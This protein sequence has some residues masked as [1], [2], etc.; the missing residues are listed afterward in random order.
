MSNTRV[1]FCGITRTED[2]R[3]A[4]SL[5]VDALGLVFVGRSVRA[6]TPQRAAEICAALP[7]LVT[8]VGLFMNPSEN[9][10]RDVLERVPLNWLQF[11]GGE[12]PEF[13]GR[14]GLPYIKALPMA[15]PGDVQYAPWSGA[16]A[17]L[18]DGH[19]AGAMGGSGEAFDWSRAVFPD[20]PWILAGGLTPEN[21]RRAVDATAADAVDVSSGIETEPGVKNATLMQR[22]MENLRNG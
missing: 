6:V 16:S 8:T 2:A 13:C 19:A 7:P 9:E 10:V 12:T 3:A 5:G 21:V 15:S 14:F 17:L 4:A 11:H 1:K 18:L 22:F 20:R